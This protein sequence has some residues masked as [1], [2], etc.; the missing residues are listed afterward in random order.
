MPPM[1]RCVVAAALAAVAAEGAT[2]VLS[3]ARV[4]AEEGGRA[5]YT[6]VLSEAPTADV[7]VAMT[8]GDDSLLKFL[9]S[10]SLTF[11]SS[12]WSAEQTVRVKAKSNGDDSGALYTDV[13]VTHAASSADADFDG[14]AFSASDEV[15]VR[16]Y[17]DDS[18]PCAS[19]TFL[20]STSGAA[21]ADCRSCTAGNYSATAGA[22]TCAACP[23]GYACPS[24]AAA[25]ICPKGTAAALGAAACAPCASGSYA[26]P[27]ARRPAP[28]CPPGYACADASEPPVA[29]SPASY[30]LGA[31]TS[32]SP[33]PAGSFCALT[34]SE[35][36]A[37][38]AARFAVELGLLRP[39]PRGPRLRVDERGAG[40]VRRRRVRAGGRDGVRRLRRGD[41]RERD[42]RAALP[43]PRA[44]ARTAAAALRERHRVGRRRDRVRA[45]PRGDLPAAAAEFCAVC[46]AGR[47][48]ADP[49]A[50]PCGAGSYAG[51]GAAACVACAAGTAAAA[52]ATYCYGCPA[53][54]SCGDAAT[55]PV[56]R[57]DEYSL[58]G[59][60][61]ACAKCPSGYQCLSTSTAPRPCPAGTRSPEGE[62]LC[63]ACD[64]GTA[65]ARPDAPQ[66]R[67][68]PVGAWCNPASELTLCPLG[69]YGNVSAGASM[70]D[71][72]E[73]CD[74]GYYC[75]RTGTT[76]L[77]RVLCPAGF[78]C[79]L[80]SSYPT[81]CPAGTYNDEYGAASSA[82][83]RDCARGFYCQAHSTIPNQFPCEKGY[84][85]PDA[86]ASHDAYPCPA[87]TFSDQTQLDDAA[88]GVPC[89]VGHYCP[90]ASTSPTPCA[91]GTYNFD[92][93]SRASTDCKSCEAGWA[94]PVPGMFYMKERCDAGHYCPRGTT[95][96]D[97]HPCPS[98]TYG[99]DLERNLTSSTECTTC[100]ARYRCLGGTTTTTI[101]DCV[102]G[103]YCE[104][105]SSAA[106]PCS[107]GSYS[108][109]T[110]LASDGEC[111]TCP[112][113]YYCVG[114]GSAP[115]GDCAAAARTRTFD[116]TSTCPIGTFGNAS[117]LRRSEDCTPCSPG[118]FCDG[119]G[120]PGPRGPCDPQR[121]RIGAYVGAREAA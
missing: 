108:N 56:A 34:S 72:C 48:C 92:P 62:T 60:A 40:G 90:E 76:A 99:E 80:G 16:I 86:T 98:G 107:A 45:V 19:G 95:Y 78:Y 121:R 6:V 77:T 74:Q 91:A 29:C 52:S 119:L 49:R 115:S 64:A 38:E 55:G 12:D 120:R 28:A 66:S 14:A 35:A 43:A 44:S 11:T 2:V 81:E 83:C 100:P 61:T 20:P 37:C 67:A 87:G 103:Y 105:G 110:N 9:T 27:R 116:P 1:L 104:A 47:S 41:L 36:Q 59:N 106:K 117:A 63:T 102:A 114:A 22:A 53:G 68:C 4:Y 69:Y 112:A 89:L 73:L 46:P 32:C 39:L 113:G 111:S 13:A 5:T 10:A 93:G 15:V 79:E 57:A 58:G 31:A 25:T 109:R 42:R 7:T 75:P 50:P 65:C 97:Q 26:R 70:A 84:F 94:C 85:C 88:E 33:C 17:D 71:A 96:A 23:A 24:A 21:E 30:A 118:Y 8:I 82:Y 54:F 18:C 101:G 3:K 51:A